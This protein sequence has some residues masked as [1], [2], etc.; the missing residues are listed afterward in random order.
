MAT[1]TELYD[2]RNDSE[3]RN[4]VAVAVVIAAEEK[5]SGTPTTAEAQ[6]AVNA[7]SN[8][9]EVAKQVINLVLAANNSATPTQILEATDAAIQTNVDAV[10]DGLVAAGG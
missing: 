9:G 1:Y 3:F 10:V 6:W 5:L 7:I 4:K 2:L 8:P